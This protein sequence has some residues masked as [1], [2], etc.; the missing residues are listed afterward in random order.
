MLLEQPMEVNRRTEEE[1][2]TP[3]HLTLDLGPTAPTMVKLLLNAGADPRLKDA[4][5]LTPYDWALNVGKRG[6]ADILNHATNKKG[7]ISNGPVT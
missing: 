6:I 7:A 2:W 5:A 3:L 1:G 4:K